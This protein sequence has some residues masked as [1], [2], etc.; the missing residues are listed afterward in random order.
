MA[1]KKKPK[2]ALRSAS[3][4]Q[5]QSLLDNAWTL[6]ERP[7]LGIPECTGR[8]GFF[9][10]FKSARRHAEKAQAARDDPARLKKLASRG[11]R[12]GRAY[13]AALL[14]SLSDTVPHFGQARLPQGNF[15][16]IYRGTA[17]PQYHVAMQHW[18]DRALRLLGAAEYVRRRGYVVYSLEEGMLCTHRR[19]A[20]PA[21]FVDL[22]MG[23]LDLGRRDEG[24]FTCPHPA[25]RPALVL[26]W[27]SAGVVARVCAACAGERSTLASIASHMRARDMAKDFDVVADLPPI[28]G[29][30][31]PPPADRE[32]ARKYL[33]GE[34]ND[35]PFL[36]AAESARREALRKREGFLLVGGERAFPDAASFASA[37]GAAPHEV[38]ALGA[39][40]SGWT[41]PIVLPRAS[42][43][44]LLE[45]LWAERGRE[46]LA[47]AAGDANGAKLFEAEA[48]AGRIAELVRRAAE[49]GEAT[50][51]ARALPRYRSLDPAPALADR[52]ARA[53]RARGKPDAARAAAEAG[54]PRGPPM[55]VALA[56][57]AALDEDKGHA[58]KFSSEEKE[59]ADYVAP[60]V[61]ALLSGEPGGYH[62]ALVNLARKTG[63]A[64]P[65]RL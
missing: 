1:E 46:A 38:R 37:A 18:P 33:R 13:A 62:D 24:T 61:R 14:A 23:E 11:N 42:V 34:L 19:F 57:L 5:E 8:C 15:P 2:R 53:F 7:L 55:G 49:E 56:I 52:A 9:C 64:D 51:V 44:L 21:E 60:E 58:W 6:R 36:D 25:A 41:K 4:V 29:L 40:T 48:D 12:I 26:K 32:S 43:A 16:Y 30:D 50:R 10:P 45:S 47:A 65:T 31:D 17:K 39:A 54:I 27:L 20:P 63:S 59:V 28:A 3:K 35:R 22:E